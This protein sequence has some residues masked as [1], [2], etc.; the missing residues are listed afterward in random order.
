MWGNTTTD[1]MSL[2]AMLQAFQT[3]AGS[4]GPVAAGGGGLHQESPRGMQFG[5]QGM[6]GGLSGALG[7]GLMGRMRGQF[8]QMPGRPQMPQG[9][10][11]QIPQRHPMGESAPQMPPQQSP[12]NQPPPM[13]QGLGSQSQ[14]MFQNYMS[15]IFNNPYRPPSMPGVYGQGGFMSPDMSLFRRPSQPAPSSQPIMGPVT[16]PGATG[17]GMLPQSNGQ[18]IDPKTGVWYRELDL[19]NPGA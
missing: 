15:R 4:Q 2:M 9:R 12:I 14:G 3:Q 11:E 17:N 6:F 13:M 7:G 16:T 18:F 8:S 1:P 5:N 19:L 10:T